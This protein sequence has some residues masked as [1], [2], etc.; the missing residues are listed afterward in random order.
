MVLVSQ[1]HKSFGT[2]HAVRGVSFELKPGQIAGLLGPN[3]AGKTTTIRMIAGYLMPDAGKVMLSGFDTRESPIAAR[4]VLGYMPESTPL[5][6]EMKV[7]EYLGFRAKLFGIPRAFQKKSCQWAMERCWLT[8]VES[9]R[10]GVL[11][12]GYRQRVGLAASLLHNPKVLILDE[13]TNGLD[14]A[15]IHETRRLVRE[16]AQDRTTLICSH[17]LPEVER[18][19]DRVLVI[20]GGKLRAD[21]TTADLTR[22]AASRYVV[23]ARDSR[24]G[25][26]DRVSKIWASVPYVDSVS[27]KRAQNAPLQQI[28][29]TEWV[30]AARAGS[31]DLREPIAL[32]AQ[33]NNIFLRELRVEGTTLEGV[34][35][36]LLDQAAEEDS[37][38]PPPGAG[39][40]GSSGTTPP[41]T[42]AAVP[43]AP[44]AAPAP[45][46]AA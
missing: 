44:A 15:Q 18:V 45:E 19:C 16:L 35:M 43:S 17:I 12:K 7:R 10:I 40:G 21:G 29:W 25:D 46:A 14:P 33:Q 42:T 3:G 9:R 6:P 11:S 23:S 27:V 13:P 5:Y 39:G 4:R 38:P 31:P 2:V 41:V 36:H 26:H 24:V 37:G 20:A 1:V 28:G 8:D 32:A 22:L 34:F 30:I